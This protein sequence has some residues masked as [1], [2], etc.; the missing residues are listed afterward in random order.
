MMLCCKSQRNTVTTLGN[1]F[2]RTHQY[3]TLAVIVT[4]RANAPRMSDNPN[5][6]GRAFRIGQSGRAT[7]W[8][9]TIAHCER[10]DSIERRKSF[11]F[12]NQGINSTVL[13]NTR[14]EIPTIYVLSGPGFR[15]EICLICDTAL[16]ESSFPELGQNWEH[17]IGQ[18]G[19][20]ATLSKGSREACV[21]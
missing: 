7:P 6:E 3:A 2:L 16:R 19:G 4:I 5:C 9:S 13:I 21:A 18:S 12:G 17:Q 8:Q 1:R 10:A 15:A 14:L 20:E 11:P